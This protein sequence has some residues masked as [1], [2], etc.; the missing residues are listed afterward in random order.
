MS[1]YVPE[2]E[3]VLKKLRAVCPKVVGVVCTDREI[4]GVRTS[5]PLTDAEVEAIEKAI[6]RRLRKAPDIGRRPRRAP[7]RLG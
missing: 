1:R 4:L 2:P 6:G 3:D 7:V 5:E